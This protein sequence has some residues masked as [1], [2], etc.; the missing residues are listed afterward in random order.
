M[1]KR[2]YTRP[3]NGC[4]IC[5]WYHGNEHAKF[6]NGSADTKPVNIV[7]YI[8]LRCMALYFFTLHCLYE[9]LAQVMLHGDPCIW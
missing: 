7:L 5:S 6:L 4:C 8:G 9:C 3:T 1:S 2:V